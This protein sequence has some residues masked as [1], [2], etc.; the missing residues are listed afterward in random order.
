MRERRRGI[1]TLLVA[2]VCALALSLAFAPVVAPSGAGPPTAVVAEVPVT[3]LE[4]VADSA[5]PS[6]Y[7]CAES[8]LVMPGVV[9]LSLSLDTADVRCGDN[10][11]LTELVI[12][13]R[14]MAAPDHPLLL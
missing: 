10:Y 7:E 6:A 9:Q 11:K 5:T 2:A 1:E 14:E 3:G 4:L 8:R 12:G 13:T